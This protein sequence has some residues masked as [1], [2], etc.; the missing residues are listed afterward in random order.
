M[1]EATTPTVLC[2]VREGVAT[3][4]LSRPLARNAWTRQMERELH[5]TLRRLDDDGDARVIVLT[6]AGQHFCPGADPA[7][8][9]AVGAGALAVATGFREGAS[10]PPSLFD[11]RFS[12]LWAIRKPIIAAINGPAAGIGL[13]LALYCDWR[14][15]SETARLAFV[16]SKIGLVAE[17]GAAWLLSRQVGSARAMELLLGG[18]VWT[19]QEAAAMGI[20]NAAHPAEGFAESVQAFARDIAKTASPYSLASIKEQVYWGMTE[21]LNEAIA[22][23]VRLTA[24]AVQGPDFAEA[25]QARKARRPAMFVR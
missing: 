14:I 23:S 15:A 9:D 3:V 24:D 5:D 13:V 20:V 21:T 1:S 6:G 18:R 19:G 2:D 17:Q 12:Y 10:S 7:V 25:M 16:F 4:T 11:G 22:R 8:L